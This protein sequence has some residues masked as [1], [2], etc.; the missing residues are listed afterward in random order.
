M[1]SWVTGEQRLVELWGTVAGSCWMVIDCRPSCPARGAPAPPALQVSRAGG[2]GPCRNR[3]ENHVIYRKQIK[4]YHR[5][6]FPVQVRVLT[7]Q[8]V[9]VA[10]LSDLKGHQPR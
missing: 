7:P 10:D 5:V 4:V 1:E 3:G 6:P 2:G 9:T 8:P